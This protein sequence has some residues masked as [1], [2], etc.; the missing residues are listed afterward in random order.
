MCVL[1]NESVTLTFEVGTWFLDAIHRRLDLVDICAKLFHNTSMYDKVTVRTRM[2][3]D[4]LTVQL[5]YAS[6]QGG[7]KIEKCI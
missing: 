4:R 7:I 6:L 2:K 3:W 5:Y 1:Q